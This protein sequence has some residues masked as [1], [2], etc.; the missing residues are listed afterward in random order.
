MEEALRAALDLSESASDIV[1][2]RRDV[3]A[4]GSI[5]R[6][7]YGFTFFSGYV[8]TKVASERRVDR[9][10]WMLSFD[11]IGDPIPEEWKEAVIDF[12]SLLSASLPPPSILC[13][14]V[15]ESPTPLQ[16]TDSPVVVCK[17]SLRYKVLRGDGK[18]QIEDC[19]GYLLQPRDSSVSSDGES[20][21][22]VV[23]SAATAAEVVRRRLGPFKTSVIRGLAARGIPFMTI[24]PIP[25]TLE[26]MLPLSV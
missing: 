23:Q 1:D 12:V 18:E 20:W 15:A 6:Y 9:L 13:D 22:L 17:I 11:A 24:T 8:S 25:G 21:Q 7:R 4:I 19:D 26:P 16:H 14:V 5:L 2:Q 3:E 10:N